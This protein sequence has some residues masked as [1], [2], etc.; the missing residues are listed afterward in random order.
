MLLGMEREVVQMRRETFCKVGV[1]AGHLLDLGGIGFKVGC[2]CNNE[3]P[4]NQ[5]YLPGEKINVNCHNCFHQMHISFMG[6]KCYNPT[7]KTSQVRIDHELPNKGTCKH[8]KRTFRWYRYGCCGRCFSCDDCHIMG[9]I[10][11]HEK[12]KGI[13]MLCGYCSK[14]QPLADACVFCHKQLVKG[15]DTTGHWEGGYG[16]RDQATLSRKDNKK[17]VG[18]TKKKDKEK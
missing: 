5:L 10:A 18:M 7:L 17:Y 3:I 14:E 2:V 12:I 8:M 11:V 9:S 1:T 4:K 13:T 16:C 15:M 6:L